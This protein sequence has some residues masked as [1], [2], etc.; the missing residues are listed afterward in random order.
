MQSIFLAFQSFYLSILLASSGSFTVKNDNIHSFFLQFWLQ[1]LNLPASLQNKNTR[2]GPF[3]WK[4]ETVRTAKSRPRKNQSE[5]SDL[6]K[7]GFAI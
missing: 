4:W 1:I 6:P 7:T 3:P 2:V 5:H